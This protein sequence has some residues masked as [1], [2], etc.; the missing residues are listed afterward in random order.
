MIPLTYSWDFETLVQSPT[1]VWAWSQVNVFNYSDVITGNSME[2][3]FKRF[4]DTAV[5]VSSIT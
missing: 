1:R 3:L 4:Q 5:R 2:S